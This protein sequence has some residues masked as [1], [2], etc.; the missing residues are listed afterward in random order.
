MTNRFETRPYRGLS[1]Q[2]GNLY[3]RAVSIIVGQRAR[4][5]EAKSRLVN[6]FTGSYIRDLLNSTRGS[7]SESARPS[8]LP[9]VALQKIISCQK[10]DAMDLNHYCA[11]CA[12]PSKGSQG[13]PPE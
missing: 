9:R 4:L 6:Q 10:I 8:G 13:R 5:K 3:M 7:I 11:R 12:R 2:A 1:S